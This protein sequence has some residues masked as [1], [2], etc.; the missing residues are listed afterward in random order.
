MIRQQA[1]DPAVAE[2][3]K[4]SSR[5]SAE[6]STPVAERKRKAKEK[7]KSAGRNR[8]MLDL[9]VDIQDQLSHMATYLGCP[10]SQVAGALIIL[11]MANVDR[12]V[13]DL[14]LYRR[15]SRSPKFDF[16]IDLDEIAKLS[17]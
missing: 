2:L 16:L 13:I 11:G 10:I 9:S 12:G 3:L 8:I 4:E 6:R 7:A 15:T 14:R 17:S 5:R 1:I